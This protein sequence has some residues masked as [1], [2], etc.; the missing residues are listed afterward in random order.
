M[1]DIVRQAIAKWPNVPA[2]FGWLGL[3]ARGQWYMRDDATQAR[4]GFPAARGTLLRHEKLIAFIERNYEADAQ[5]RW[6]F[7]NGPQ[8]VYV[9]LEATPLIWRL[10]PGGEPVAHTGLRAAAVHECLVDEAGRVYL[11]C[12]AGFGLVHSLDVAAVAH[13]VEHGRWQPREVR[14]ADLPGAY[15]FVLSPAALAADA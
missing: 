8:R 4:G 3:D 5:G 13:D 15:G 11:D 1:D 10:E 9:E 2:C 7:Q 12:A 6:F 14:G